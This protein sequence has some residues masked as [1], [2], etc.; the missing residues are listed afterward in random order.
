ME[1][2]ASIP[3]TEEPIIVSSGRAEGF[4]E[5]SV[6]VQAP[7]IVISPEDPSRPG[8]STLSL[9]PTV[10]LFLNDVSFLGSNWI[11]GLR[12][13][14]LSGRSG[15]SPPFVPSPSLV[16]VDIGKVTVPADVLTS[17]APELFL[18]VEEPSSV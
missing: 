4:P 13:L 18:A 3:V 7:V 10:N 12:K 1:E 15:P 16:E 8:T 5:S 9:S 6:Q 11:E 14:S 17:C 2:H